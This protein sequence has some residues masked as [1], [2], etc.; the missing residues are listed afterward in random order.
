MPLLKLWLLIVY[1]LVNVAHGQTKGTDAG[2]YLYG[3]S[4]FYADSIHGYGGHDLIVAGKGDDTIRGGG[5]N[6]YILGGEGDD[7]IRGGSGDDYIFGSLGVDT[8]RGGS[9]DDYITGGSGDDTIRGG[10]GDDVILG[11]NG[12]DSIHGGGGNDYILGG[13]GS[14][15]DYIHGGLGD[16]SLHG[17]G[18][19]DVIVGGYGDD[20]IT[21]GNGDDSI[22][23]GSGDDYI[24]GGPGKD[25]IV[26]GPGEDVIHAGSG[27]DLLIHDA[28]SSVGPHVGNYSGGNDGADTLHL[29]VTQQQA[30]E[31]VGAVQAFWEWNN[32]GIFDFGVYADGWNIVVRGIHLL[33]LEIAD[34]TPSPSTSAS[35]ADPAPPSPSSDSPSTSPSPSPSPVRPN[36]VTISSF[37]SFSVW[38]TAFLGFSL[39]SI[40]TSAPAI[41]STEVVQSD[42]MCAGTWLSSSFPM[43]PLTVSNQEFEVLDWGAGVD[44]ATVVIHDFSSAS[45]AIGAAHSLPSALHRAATQT[46]SITRWDANGNKISDGSLIFTLRMGSTFTGLT[47]EMHRYDDFSDRPNPLLQEGGTMA[48]CFPVEAGCYQITTVKTSSVTGFTITTSPSPSP[49]VTGPSVTGGSEDWWYGLL[50]L[51]VIPF[52]ILFALYL[53]ISAKRQP[54]TSFVDSLYSDATQD[55]LPAYPSAMAWQT[56]T[57]IETPMVLDSFAPLD[58]GDLDFMWEYPQSM[59]LGSADA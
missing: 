44:R 6:D 56:A 47:P 27:N 50:A 42:T 49:S 5:G 4:G 19:D 52:C 17:H 31:L 13:S 54:P 57:P 22:H 10:S 1:A 58:D 23:G 55:G 28:S 25:V 12:D 2:D 21:G 38:V 43:P 9:G 26:A 15:D 16:D 37:A 41:T 39:G 33:N 40:P 48:D 36:V 3:Y 46:V 14:G 7:T 30:D 35:P 51:L 34:P 20:T 11:G 29:I 24:L 32:V 59:D 18:G 8:I 53:W 45:A